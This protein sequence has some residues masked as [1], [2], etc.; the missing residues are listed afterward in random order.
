ME[1]SMKNQSQSVTS[2]TSTGRKNDDGKPRWDLL[3][4]E[5]LDGVAT[6]LEFGGRKYAAHNWRGG[7]NT[8]RLLGA[9][10][11]HFGAILR[12]EDVDSES[13]LPHWAHLGCCIMFFS[14]MIKHKPELDDRY[15]Y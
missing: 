2:Q 12:G 1:N 15:K 5:F 3:D 11:R 4:A 6:V 13:K 10:G 14:W 7:I 8:S 9:A